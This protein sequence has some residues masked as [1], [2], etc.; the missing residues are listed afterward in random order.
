M[1]GQH[2]ATDG[3]GAFRASRIAGIRQLAEWFEAHP[4][5]PV[6]TVINVHI[7]FKVE[8]EPD[9]QTRVA[10]ALAAMK[11][12]GVTVPTESDTTISGAAQVGSNAVVYISAIKDEV[13][14]RRYLA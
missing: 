8:D 11:E 4:E 13:R 12:A 7:F 10:G 5:V 6:P 2:S 3:S 9:E 1:A 14:G